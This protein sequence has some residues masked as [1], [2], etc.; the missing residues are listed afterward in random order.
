MAPTPPNAPTILIAAAVIEDADGR[1]LFVRK[2]GTTAFMQPGGKLEDG[3]AADWALSRELVEELGLH[4]PVE[5]LIPIGRFSAPAANEP[6]HYVDAWVFHAPLRSEPV[7]QAEIDEL[8][9]VDPHDLGDRD[10]APLSRDVI[11]PLLLHRR[12]RTRG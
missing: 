12:P 9:W 8:A 4:V 10:I 11:I 2:H 5:D 3:E 6:G 7:A 1:L